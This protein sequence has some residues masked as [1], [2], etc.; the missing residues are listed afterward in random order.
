[1]HIIKLVTPLLPADAVPNVNVFKPCGRIN[2]DKYLVDT[3]GGLTCSKLKE[4][5]SY[6]RKLSGLVD[7]RMPKDSLHLIIGLWHL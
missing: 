1:M 7:A 5:L 2:C 4:P 3:L 6:T